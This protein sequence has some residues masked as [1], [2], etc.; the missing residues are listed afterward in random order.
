MLSVKYVFS[1]VICVIIATEMVSIVFGGVLHFTSWV[2]YPASWY[3]D[4][5]EKMLMTQTIQITCYIASALF[6]G[7]MLVFLM[8]VRWRK[9]KENVAALTLG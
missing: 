5:S 4:H 9:F 3:P 2:P 6:S 8:A 1:C 7:G